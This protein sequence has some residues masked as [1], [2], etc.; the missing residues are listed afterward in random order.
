MDETVAEAI[1]TPQEMSAADAA[2]IAAGTP[3]L[4]LM[5]RAGAAV[6]AAARRLWRGGSVVVLAG[7]GNNGGDGWVAARLL[8]RDGYRLTVAAF[9]EREALRGDAAAMAARF[10]GEIVAAEPDALRD[11]GLVIDALFGAGFRLPMPE[12]AAQVVAAV[13]DRG[14]P[15]VAVDLPSG[16]EGATG[17]IGETAIRAQATVTFF[18]RKPG[19]LLLPGR[20]LC[21]AVTVTDIGIAAGVLGGIGP[22]AFHNAPAVWLPAWPRLDAGTHK[23]QRG[24]AVVVGGPAS[25]TGAA[26]LAATAA[27]R[28]GAGAVSMASPPD[29]LAAYA[30][31]LT[32]VMLR[33]FDGAGGLAELLSDARIRSVVIGP[34]AGP[35][36]ATADL[37]EV[38]LAR[39]VAAVLDADALTSFAD[40]PERLF[41]AIARAG[42]PVALTPHDGE[43]ARLFPDIAGGSR[44]DRARA[45]AVR[46][47]AIIVS[48]GAD[49]VVAAPDG[50]ATIA[51]NAPPTLATAGSGDV[52]AGM[53]GGLLAQ[54]MPPFEAAS[55]AVWLHGE[56][57]RAFGAGLTAED[58]P[59]ALPA[60]L[61][62]LD[63]GQSR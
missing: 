15:V 4:V 28:I 59:G 45:A 30:A 41:A 48:K 38:V 63:L 33:P 36:P 47:G 51:D 6:A 56:A 50:R 20:R 62:A 31:H 54:G 34:A 23:Y 43:F 11:S 42:R 29:A 24:H 7:P 13:N 35:G 18:R 46:S 17:S 58:L 26:R 53:I 16:V 57:A 19:H 8:R 14:A 44:L 9:T 21:G 3:G 60:V 52:L 25:A 32:A 2:T 1:L 27:L 22:T 61:R 37:V 49:T 12:R 5:E 40:A 10:G 39:E 55:A